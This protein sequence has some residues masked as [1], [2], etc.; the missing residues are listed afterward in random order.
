VHFGV[1]SLGLVNVMAKDI[2]FLPEWQKQVWGGLNVRPEGGVSKELLDAQAAGEPADT[3]APEAFLPR[4]I[5]VLNQIALAKLGYRMFR[6]H[7]LFGGS[8]GACAP[9][10]SS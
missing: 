2:A 3:S 7:E 4:G 5:E 1:N 6:A 9:L 8:A 10:P